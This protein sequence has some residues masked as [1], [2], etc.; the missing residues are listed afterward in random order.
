MARIL[1]NYVYYTAVGHVVE[2]LRYARG[3]HDANAGSE[4]H[5]A[6]P[7]ATAW[8]LCEGCPWIARTYR[9]RL[10]GPEPGGA[11]IPALP[12]E[13]DYIMDNNLMRVETGH[14]G[15]PGQP[16]RPGKL[17]RPDGQAPAPIGPQERA[18][19]AYYERTDAELIARRGRGVLSPAMVRPAGLRYAPGAPVRLQVPAGSR[20]FASSY[21]HDGPRICIILAGSGTARMYPSVASWIAILA[22]LRGRFPA[23]RFYLTGARAPGRGQTATV[24]YSETELSQILGSDDKITDCYDIGLWHQVALL[25]RCDLLLSPHTG[26]AFLALCVG[27]PWLTISGGNWPE[28]FFNDVPFYSVLPD[29]PDYPY[30]GGIDAYDGGPRI[31]CMRPERLAAKI[32]EILEGA[33]FLLDPGCTYARA[34]R[35]HRANISRARIRHDRMPPARPF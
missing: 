30:V 23:A 22:A 8:E 20:A 16:G 32:P 14:R 7:D 35:R 27:T 21:D 13:W 1:L 31:P 12:A 9:I 11:A 10:T 17:V 5:V 29:N 4:V 26:F 6:L 24:A 2:A 3:L 25:E 28:Y 19:L 33:A 15:P 34:W 18:V